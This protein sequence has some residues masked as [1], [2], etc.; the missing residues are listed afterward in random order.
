M[1]KLRLTFFIILLSKIVLGQSVTISGYVKDSEAGECL[2]NAFIYESSTQK[3]TVTNNSG[4]YSLTLK[5]GK[6]LNL[7]SGYIG[8]KTKDKQFTPTKD[9]VINFLLVADNELQT[10]TV[11]GEKNVHQLPDVSI[12]E[13]PMKD[14][15][16]MPSLSGEVDVLK[17]F[18][19][20]PGVQA[21]Q[22]GASALY[23]RGGSPDQNLYLIDDVP[24][25]YVNH[26]GGFISVFDD[27]A[28]NTMQLIKG[29]FPA[30][31]GGRLSSV[32]DMRMKDGNS[33]EI[34]GE[35]K[36]GVIATKLFIEGPIKRNKTTFMLSARRA[37][38]D[39]FT[40]VLSIFTAD[41]FVAAYSFYDIYGKIHHKLS[42]KNSIYFSTYMGRDRIAFHDKDQPT[43]T[44][45]FPDENEIKYFYESHL[46][47]KWGNNMAAFRWN[48]LF[49]N[50]LFSNLVLSY[51]KFYYYSDKEYIKRI[52]PEMQ[53]I[54]HQ[55]KSYNSSVEDLTV[56]LD[57]DFYL[58]SSNKIKFGANA[59]YHVFKPGMSNYIEKDS[60]VVTDTIFGNEAINT[61]ETNFY[62]EDEI[63]IMK[64][65]SCNIGVLGTQYVVADTNFV[66]IQPR[67]VV[68]FKI[69]SN[70][71]FKLAYSQVEQNLHLLSNSG[72][73]IPTDIWLPPSENIKPQ[74]STQYVLNITYTLPKQN[75]EISVE[76][77]YKEMTN[78][79]DFKEGASYQ[80]DNSN[81][82]SI[83]ETNGFGRVKGL[84]FLIQKKTGKTTGWIAYTLSK[85]ERQFE[86]INN[87]RFYP[88]TYDNRH[89]IA[90]VINYQINEN[91]TISM[92]WVFTSGNMM[93]LAV[94]NYN[95][96]VFEPFDKFS[97]PQT[98][99]NQ[100]NGILNETV[101][102]YGGKNNF[103][104][105]AYH[106]LDLSINLEKEKKH[107]VRTWQFGLY[108]AYNQKNI[109]FL[110]YKNG[111]KD[112][113]K[114]TLFP[115]IPSVSYSFKF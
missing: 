101:Y 34:H 72:T 8:F 6:L 115:I 43:D 84:E 5:Q 111:G 91:I 57:F 7:S 87:G 104:L 11:S 110:Y 94:L 106:R 9:T 41:N 64:F 46:L 81:W 98:T 97:N 73:G 49:T 36:T 109:F 69:L 53:T 95:S 13:I 1:F 31:Y 39:L 21:G 75:I 105:P 89:N 19:L 100:V 25:Y 54:E 99:Y 51:S 37:N 61:Y 102:Y 40:R 63:K 38:I 86:N 56:K 62:L 48:H 26:L 96:M 50:K 23:V 65:F 30:H 20:M 60:T 88:S 79:I 18:Q 78:I 80:L 67:A 14:L 27:N 113:Y 10:V 22:E 74:K 15:R 55:F 33:N 42:D 35:I 24:L 12:L 76:A 16:Q 4:F 71:S 93:T 47:T 112:L 44:N 103:R 52:L 83:I 29:G 58:N 108:N 82:N 85:S 77:F 2:I 107:G 90:L 66:S 32:I 68:N 59:V 70:L 92:D 45:P 3:G 28:I 17:V 114:F